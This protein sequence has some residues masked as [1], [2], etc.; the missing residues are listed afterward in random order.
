MCI[1]DSDGSHQNNDIISSFLLYFP[2]VKPGGLYVIEDTHTLYLNR[3]GGG[4]L[5]EFS[6]YSFFKKL[7]DVINIEFWSDQ[8]SID[9]YFRTFFSLEQMPSFI[10]QGWIESIEFRN[11][12]VIIRKS[13]VGKSDKLGDRII[14]GRVAQVDD[15]REAKDQEAKDQEAK[16]KE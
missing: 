16:D 7:I 11:S 12:M 6:A 4:I 3:W 1:R 8:I 13:K 2:L 15:L 5:N 14:T 10:K 9:V